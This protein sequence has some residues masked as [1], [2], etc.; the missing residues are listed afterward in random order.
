MQQR[1]VQT[2]EM[3]MQRCWI[4]KKLNSNTFSVTKNARNFDDILYEEKK[5]RCRENE[6]GR[7][8]GKKLTL[9]SLQRVYAMALSRTHDVPQYR[10]KQWGPI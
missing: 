9:S 2:S 7:G 10:I 3:M 4:R 8:V 1:E 5:M 6:E